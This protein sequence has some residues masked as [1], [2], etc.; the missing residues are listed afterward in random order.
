MYAKSHEWAK[1]DGDVATVGISDHA[2]VGH[3][4]KG[5]RVW[6]LPGFVRPLF[7][8]CLFLKPR[9]G[10]LFL[11]FFAAAK[12]IDNGEVICLNPRS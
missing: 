8:R 3:R 2:Q 6:T 11:S 4:G 1:V 7:A 5:T 10:V 12:A 9:K